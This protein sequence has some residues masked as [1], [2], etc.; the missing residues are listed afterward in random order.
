MDA[1]PWTRVIGLPEGNQRGPGVPWIRSRCIVPCGPA[2]RA[3]MASFSRPRM[4][5]TRLSLGDRTQRRVD[6]REEE[7]LAQE[8][9]D[10]GQ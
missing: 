1:S 3:K 9:L 7:G 6:I 8:L 10:P 4:F 2:T 5:P